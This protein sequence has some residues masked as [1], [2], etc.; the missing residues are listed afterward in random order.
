MTD[1]IPPLPFNQREHEM[2]FI[3]DILWREPLI[4]YAGPTTKTP[5]EDHVIVEAEW[6]I[7]QGTKRYPP[8]PG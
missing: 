7:E 8:L 1:Q 4:I 6:A 2:W 3:G 5:I